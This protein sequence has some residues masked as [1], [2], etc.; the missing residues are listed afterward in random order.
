MDAARRAPSA[1]W[2]GELDDAV[3][4]LASGLLI[5]IPTIFT[6]D[7]WWLGDQL[8]PLDALLLLLVAY[9]LTLGAVYWIN[10]RRG[11]RRGWQYL[12]DALEALALAIVALVLVFWVLGQIGAGQSPSGVLGRVAVSV[13]PLALGIAVANHLL[14]RDGS[15]LDPDTGDASAERGWSA[16]TGWR[17]TL[18][19]LAAT[20]G[21]A[22]FV[23][24]AIVPIDDLGEVATAVPT[25]NL[26][27]VIGLSL[28]ASYAVVFA[29]GFA[30]EG[31]RRRTPGPLQHPLVETVGSYVV[32]LGVSWFV[33][34]LFGRIDDGT[35]PL[36][37]YA[38]TVLLAFPA[39]MAAAAGRLAV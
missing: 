32:A 28:A 27:L 21:G 33:L 35:A 23:A 12:A 30:G 31:D 5:G 2:R 26:P 1:A 20:I 4:G 24:M 34:R 38:K 17:R 11:V 36:V 19:E 29:A 10:F 39:S 18:L 9:V 13:P 22:V 8:A 14:P 7:V 6:V 16:G 25:G 3:R 15:R 37:V